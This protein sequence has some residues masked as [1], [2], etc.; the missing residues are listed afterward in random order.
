MAGTEAPHIDIAVGFW[1]EHHSW[2]FSFGFV[3]ADN[4]ERSA[5]HGMVI[6][7]IQT[8]H[9]NGQLWFW[10][11]ELRAETEA[12]HIVR[13]GMLLNRTSWLKT[14]ILIFWAEWRAEAPHVKRSECNLNRNMALEDDDFDL[15]AEGR[16]RSAG[17]GQ[18]SV[19]FGTE[20]KW[21]F[22][23]RE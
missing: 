3:Q 15:W 2:Y 12:L 17:H 4:E 19:N 6:R 18:S 14:C 1:T 22:W 7:F 5:T 9:R 11:F 20:V 21:W 16:D 10:T 23:E 13:D 8:E